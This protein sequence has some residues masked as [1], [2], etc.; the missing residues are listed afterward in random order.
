[1]RVRLPS[2]LSTFLLS[3]LLSTSA[4]AAT[5]YASQNN[6]A[7]NVPPGTGTGIAPRDDNR[8][9]IGGEQN[10]PQGCSRS[11]WLAGRC[12]NRP[13]P[14][15]R[16]IVV[17]PAATTTPAVEA[18]LTDD[19]EG[20]RAAKVR[21]MNANGNGDLTQAKQLDEWLWKNCRNYSDDLRQLEQDR[22]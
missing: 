6:I 8:G 5:A 22:M 19:W 15:R 11:D 1:V 4:I 3:C 7:Q 20:C 2:L 17:V 14:Y 21:Q 13:E 9:N 16:P 12:N 18:P 10:P